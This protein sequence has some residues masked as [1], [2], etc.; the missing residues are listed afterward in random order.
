MKFICAFSSD[1][2]E[3]YKADIYRAMC[4][5]E[6]YILHF[7]YREKYVDPALREGNPS[8]V[9]RR[10]AIF[11][12]HGNKDDGQVVADN[13][14]VRFA[15]IM[16]HEVSS[17]TGVFH[18]YLKLG[19]FCDLV[20]DANN[21]AEKLPS[22][23]FF[24]ELECEEGQ[25]DSTWHGRVKS[26]QPL[27]PDLL[28][29]RIKDIS[30]DNGE[31]VSIHYPNDGRSCSYTLTGGSRY[32]LRLALANPTS[33]KES[34]QLGE[35]SGSISINSINPIE[36][37]A[38]ADDISVPLIVHNLNVLSQPA[39]LTFKP[40]LA[41]GVRSDYSS[42]IEITLHTGWFRPLIFGVFSLTAILSLMALQSTNPNNE[43][44]ST[45]TFLIA[46]AAFL[47]SS[48]ALFFWFNKK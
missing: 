21:P 20:V 46:S 34:V 4:L 47:I 24:S 43:S 1:F 3:L 9:G 8:L 17:D 31:G 40:T 48:S 2:R 15:N 13:V 5:P 32:V 16:K 41:Q 25:G 36:T 14:S 6:G 19:D 18:V 29:F 33:G 11:Y 38:L 22:N 10:V 45:A 39:L 26:L 28:Y 27:L 30:K 7:R 35:S 37:S 42:S 12:V 44:P 23:L